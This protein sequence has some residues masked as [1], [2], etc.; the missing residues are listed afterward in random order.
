[1]LFQEP[2]SHFSPRKWFHWVLPMKSCYVSYNRINT[3]LGTQTTLAC[4]ASKNPSRVQSRGFTC[5]IQGKFLPAGMSSSCTHACRNG[6]SGAGSRRAGGVQPSPAAS[7]STVLII[8]HHLVLPGVQEEN[9]SRQ[10]GVPES[11]GSVPGQPRLQ[12][13]PASHRRG[14]WQRA[15]SCSSWDSPGRSELIRNMV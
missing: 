3:C 9:R 5:S 11:P 2:E 6:L 14:T 1:M 8:I 10:E 7:Y 15:V 4:N 12:G 13:E